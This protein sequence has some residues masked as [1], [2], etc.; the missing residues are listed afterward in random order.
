MAE[1]TLN[2][3]EIAVLVADI[4]AGTPGPWR[5]S[6]RNPTTVIVEGGGHVASTFQSFKQE[7]RDE[8]NAR[9]IARLPELEAAYLALQADAREAAMQY[10]SDAGQAA[11]RITAL[12]DENERL[13]K[14]LIAADGYLTMGLDKMAFNVTRA[15]LHHTGKDD[16]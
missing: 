14:A 1:K 9:R 15:A 4:E 8:A 16:K 10:L 5:Q 3:G 13:E 12:M 2:P 11:E 6:K 7:Y